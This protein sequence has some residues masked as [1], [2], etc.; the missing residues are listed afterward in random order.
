M[1]AAEGAGDFPVAEPFLKAG[2]VEEVAAG[3]AVGLRVGVESGEADGAVLL[4]RTPEEGGEPLR[5]APESELLGDGGVGVVVRQLPVVAGAVRV[6]DADDLEDGAEELLQYGDRDG[7]VNEDH[8]EHALGGCR[9][10]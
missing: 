6:P 4:R 10:A 9:H 5:R 8:G 2:L 1:G 7:R 3:E